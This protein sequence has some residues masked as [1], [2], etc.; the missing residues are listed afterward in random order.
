MRF[1]NK[2]LPLLFVGLFQINHAQNSSQVSGFTNKVESY[3]GKI[4]QE[5]EIDRYRAVCNRIS[6]K[7]NIDNNGKVFRQ[8]IK[9]Y[10]SGM[11]KEHTKI[12]GKS[13]GIKFLIAEI[14]R[15]DNKIFF[16]KIYETKKT[17]KQKYIRIRR[18]AV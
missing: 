13:L 8:T 14:V 6:L 18:D 15:I 1:L 17:G 7:G 3:I 11:K 10:K 9:M 12:Y 5:S 16:A 2:I 4:A